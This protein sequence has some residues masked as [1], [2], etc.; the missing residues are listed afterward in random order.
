MLSD[1]QIKEEISPTLRV[2]VN[3]L[4]E[5]DRRPFD[6]QSNGQ[7]SSEEFDAAI[8]CEVGAEMEDYENFPTGPYEHDNQTF[9]DEMGSNDADPNVPSY[10][11]VLYCFSPKTFMPVLEGALKDKYFY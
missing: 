2:I 8:D 7:K 6:F 11:Q 5:T 4:D 10:P 3:Q 1:M 9:V